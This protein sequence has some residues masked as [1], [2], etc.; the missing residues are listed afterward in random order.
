MAGH[1]LESGRSVTSK[2]IAILQTFAEGTEHSMAEIARLTGLPISTAHRLMTELTSRRFLERTSNGQYRVGLALRMIGAVDGGP[3]SITE[4]GPCVLEDISSSIKSRVRLGVL[5]DV[6]VSYIEK[7]PGPRPSTSFSSWTKVPA[8]PTAM[9]RALLAFSPAQTVSRALDNGLRRYTEHTVTE[10][11]RFRRALAVIRLTR[12][13]VTQPE[14]EAGVYA[15]ATPV[16]GA[17]GKVVAAIELA[18]RNLDQDVGPA[19]ATLTIASRSLTRELIS[20]TPNR[21][22]EMYSAEE[23]PIWTA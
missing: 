11:D 6:N 21:Y 3:P 16:F 1:S 2:V 20:E 9:G 23:K 4:R 18:L 14:F 12:V 13:A 22:S 7:L 10:V 5:D 19:V 15:V 17:G 8:P